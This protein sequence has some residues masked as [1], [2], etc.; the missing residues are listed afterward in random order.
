MRA[1]A[2]G[3]SAPGVVAESEAF[4]SPPKFAPIRMVSDEPA[5]AEHEQRAYHCLEITG[6]P[7]TT[8]IDF[9][10]ESARRRTQGKALVSSAR[11]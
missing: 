1:P 3:R 11:R 10:C 4:T 7:V 5:F 9:G 6:E 2:H 8:T